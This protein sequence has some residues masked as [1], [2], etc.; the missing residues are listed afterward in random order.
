VHDQEMNRHY[1]RTFL[2]KS[3]S[4]TSIYHTLDKS[5]IPCL[6]TIDYALL[7]RATSDAPAPMSFYLLDGSLVPYPTWVQS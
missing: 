5:G 3:H 6:L 1:L 4:S 2:D 7:L